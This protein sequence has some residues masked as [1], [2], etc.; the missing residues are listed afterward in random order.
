MIEGIAATWL[1]VSDMS[2]AAAF[3][4]DEFELEVTPV[5]VLT[6]S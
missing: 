5:V 4:R 6:G 3:D 2:R 1:P